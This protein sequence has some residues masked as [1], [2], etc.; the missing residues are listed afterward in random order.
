V[1]TVV[2]LLNNVGPAWGWAI[3]FIWLTW[4]LYCPIPKH[5]TKLQ[6][7][8][9][10]LTERFERIEIGQVAISEEVEDVDATKIRDIHEKQGLTTEELKDPLD[11]EG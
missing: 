7:W 6:S 8:H 3:A 2:S 4:Q 10:D 5:E 1:S 9:G 11:S